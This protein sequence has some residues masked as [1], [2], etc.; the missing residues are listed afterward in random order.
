LLTLIELALDE[1]AGVGGPVDRQ[2]IFAVHGFI[3][4]SSAGLPIDWNGDGNSDDAGVSSDVNTFSV[5]LGCNFSIYPEGLAGHDDWENLDYDF[6]DSV[7]YLDGARR[8]TVS[9][10]WDPT[11]EEVL[12][13]A[14]L[15]DSDGDGISNADDNCRG[16]F[17]P[18]QVNLDGDGTGDACDGRRRA[19]IDQPPPRW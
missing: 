17:N 3:H 19:G 15:I 7:D 10:H 8:R 13:A 9:R 12:A 1:E 2:S 16:T 14:A 18:S 4:T 6:R 5:I 11:Y